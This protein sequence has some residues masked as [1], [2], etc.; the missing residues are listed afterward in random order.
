MHII[1][2]E[3]EPP[4]QPHQTQVGKRRVAA[5]GIFLSE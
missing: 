4:E 5:P 3:L 2:G 1:A